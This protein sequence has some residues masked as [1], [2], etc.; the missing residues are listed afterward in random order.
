MPSVQQHPQT[1]RMRVIG[2]AIPPGT[3]SAMTALDTKTKGKK[4]AT[5]ERWNARRFHPIL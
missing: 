1:Y 5:G 4:R 2:S 3:G